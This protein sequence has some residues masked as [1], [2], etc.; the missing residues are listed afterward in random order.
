MRISANLMNFQS[1]TS[2]FLSSHTF[3]DILSLYDTLIRNDEPG[4]TPELYIYLTVRPSCAQRLMALQDQ[5]KAGRC[6]TDVAIYRESTPPWEGPDGTGDFVL[7]P[8][9]PDS[10]SEND[11]NDDNDVYDE[12]VLAGEQVVQDETEMGEQETEANLTE[13]SEA[14]QPAEDTTYTG[15]HPPEEPTKISAEDD[16]EAAA[17]DLVD[18]DELDLSPSNQ[19]KA[20]Y[21][22]SSP[23]PLY[24]TRM[25]NCQC[26]SC[27]LEQIENWSKPSGFDH[28]QQL[29]DAPMLDC[30]ARSLNS[31]NPVSAP[32]QQ[33]SS[34]A[35]WHHTQDHTDTPTNVNAVPAIITSTEYMTASETNDASAADY[36]Q[37]ED[38]ASQS[39]SA[40]A[41]L[42]GDDKDEIDYD[43]DNVDA[44][45][46][47][48]LGNESSPVTSAK[49]EV[50][51][52]DEI[53]WESENE[54]AADE[55]TT[56]PFKPSEQVSTTP[57]K[58]MR[59]DSDATEGS[60]EQSGM[61]SSNTPPSKCIFA[62]EP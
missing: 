7:P 59:S 4:D 46:T 34:S 44:S 52:D 50:P 17:D 11:V 49:L 22:L 29:G 51:A 41:T 36:E 45:P 24:C 30:S 38:A 12:S 62:N 21:S 3:G 57:G 43:N 42:N 25:N 14:V 61:S 20:A 32:S 48:A 31:G 33:E 23:I 28:F 40:T 55:N 18:Y 37:R 15:D 16:A 13:A 5:A 26:D 56:A 19:G 54:E 6:L 27:F 10:E 58:R 1:M 39:T 35:N 47:A 8:M 60:G 2:V 53:T 9:S